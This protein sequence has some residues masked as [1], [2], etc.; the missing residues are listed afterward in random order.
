M[1]NYEIFLSQNEI[2]IVAELLVK[3]KISSQ[4]LGELFGTQ[5][6]DF[7]LYVVYVVYGHLFPVITIGDRKQ[8]AVFQWIL[9]QI[10]LL[11]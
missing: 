6:R 3:Y 2:N 11:T 1:S 4:L 10:F 5:F 9:Y 8:M 7:L